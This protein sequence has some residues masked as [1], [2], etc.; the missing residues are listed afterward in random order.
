MNDFMSENDTYEEWSESTI[1]L[2]EV[3]RSQNDA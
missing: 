3:F 2:R 1:T